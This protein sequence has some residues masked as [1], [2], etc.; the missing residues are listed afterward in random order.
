MTESLIHHAGKPL[1]QRALFRH[2]ADEHVR[3]SD[4][5][6]IGHVNNLAFAAYFETGRAL[7]LRHFT[8]ADAASRALFVLGETTIRFLSE[9]HWP[10]KIDA[11]T[12]VVEIGRRT[13]RLGQGLFVGARCIAVAESS[14]VLMDETTRK[15]RDIP[16]EVR[17]WLSGFVMAPASPPASG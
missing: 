12:G 2:W 9:A 14:L 8:I 5:D 17:A 15:S 10:A 11:G 4:T 7:F 3:W 1:Q 6:M 16:D 13:L